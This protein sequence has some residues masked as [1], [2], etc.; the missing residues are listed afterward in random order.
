MKYLSLILIL[1]FI[2]IISSFTGCC[3]NREGLDN[4]D[5]MIAGGYV[6][7]GSRPGNCA[8]SIIPGNNNFTSQELAS[9]FCFD[10][11]QKGGTPSCT[12]IQKEKNG[13]F[14]AR[15]CSSDAIQKGWCKGFPKVTFQEETCNV[16][17]GGTTWFYK[18]PDKAPP[19]PPSS[20]QF[21][22]EGCY[23]NNPRVFSNWNPNNLKDNPQRNSIC[24]KRALSTNNN[25]YGLENNNG[26]LVFN[27]NFPASTKLN[28]PESNCTN[29]F[30]VAVF[31]KSAPF[32]PPA[33]PP[34]A[35][36]NIDQHIAHIQN[37]IIG[38]GEFNTPLPSENA[39]FI[40]RQNTNITLNPAP[41]PKQ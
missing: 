41:A 2:T 4:K 17:Q 36:W 37:P 29:A 35:P 11:N 3:C 40:K 18:K 20:S 33:P 10:W 19:S 9:Q 25:Y 14:Q 30:Q 22:F 26:C 13:S 16:E 24:E 38:H 12:A 28:I 8:P 7:V 34:H 5:A 31:Q 1:L 15:G 39:I 27:D 6:N 23:S 21:R 32:H